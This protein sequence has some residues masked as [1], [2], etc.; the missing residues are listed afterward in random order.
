M[1]KD[2]ITKIISVA[3]FAFVLLNFPVLGLFG[4][5]FFL[6]GIPIAYLYIVT[7]WLLLIIFLYRTLNPRAKR[8]SK[9]D[10]KEG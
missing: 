2:R 6:F 10:K 7:V 8:P 9:K 1:P 3:L 5:G 4:K